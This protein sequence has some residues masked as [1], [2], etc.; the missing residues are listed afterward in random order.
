MR[1]FAASIV[2]I[3][4]AAAFSLQPARADE[5]TQGF[6]SVAYVTA[7]A[8]ELGAAKIEANEKEGIVSFELNGQ[9]MTA[10]LD[11]C[12]KP[13][14]CLLLLLAAGTNQ[15]KI[16]TEA[17]NKYNN[18]HPFTTALTLDGGAVAVG[19]TW[20]ALGGMPRDNLKANFT[21][22]AT[23]VPDFV[24]FLSNQVVASAQSDLKGAPATVMGVAAPRLVPLSPKDLVELRAKFETRNIH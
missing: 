1:T 20:F 8:T 9:P 24:S 11:A 5:S 3:A 13:P 12:D 10:V 23:E 6:F 2:V 22:F 15:V 18:Q 19:H 4:T 14:G 21:L 16:G 17:L 7:V